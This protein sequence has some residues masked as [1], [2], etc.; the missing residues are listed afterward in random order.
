LAR[1]HERI[2]TKHFSW[3]CVCLVWNLI[4]RPVGVLDTSATYLG[5][6]FFGLGTQMSIFLLLDRTL[7]VLC[8]V[9]FPNTSFQLSHRASHISLLKCPCAVLVVTS[10]LSS[11]KLLTLRRPSPCLYSGRAACG[12]Q[13]ACTFPAFL[14]SGGGDLLAYICCVLK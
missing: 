9:W 12:C 2:Q 6:L 7:C 11:A 14:F 13:S 4:P 1:G 10:G 8:F 5:C 3:K